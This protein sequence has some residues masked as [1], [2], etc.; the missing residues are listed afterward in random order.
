MAVEIS[1]CPV[2]DNNDIRVGT[3][4]FDDKI[5]A[6]NLYCPVCN[7]T[8]RSYKMKYKAINKWNSLCRQT[9]SINTNDAI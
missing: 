9:R 5:V 8:G 7:F 4:F 2:C 6:Y 1:R 3:C